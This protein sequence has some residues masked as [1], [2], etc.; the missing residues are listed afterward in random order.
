MTHIQNL[1]NILIVDDDADLRALVKRKFSSVN[2]HVEEA[3]SVSK[4]KKMLYEQNYD[5]IILDLMMI[6]E[7]GYALFEFLKNDQKFKW[8]PIIILSGKDD[9]DDKVKCLKLGADDYI[10]KPFNTKEIIARVDRLL[11]RSNS[12]KFFF[13]N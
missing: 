10:T 6:P 5:L 2:Y 13:N 7:S 8:I 11:T 1:G 9:I 12:R 3:S 4:A